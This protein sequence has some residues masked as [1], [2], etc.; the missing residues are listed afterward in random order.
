MLIRMSEMKQGK[1]Y[2]FAHH[3]HPRWLGLIVKNPTADGRVQIVYAPETIPDEMY[4]QVGAYRGFNTGAFWK[5]AKRQWGYGQ[6]IAK[7]E[8]KES[9]EN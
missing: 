1:N 4:K 6:W 7:I 2:V 5:L 3:S 8:G 9:C